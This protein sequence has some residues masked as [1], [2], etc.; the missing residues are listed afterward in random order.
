MFKLFYEKYLCEFHSDE[1]KIYVLN[2]VNYIYVCGNFTSM[3]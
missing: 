1:I 3:E 2:C